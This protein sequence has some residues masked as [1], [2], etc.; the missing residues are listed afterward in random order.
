MK[1]FFFS[2]VMFQSLGSNGS[3]SPQVYITIYNLYHW[4]YLD[5]K[6]MDSFFLFLL[7]QEVTFESS[8]CPFVCTT[9]LVQFSIPPTN[10][11]T[12]MCP[13]SW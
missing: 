4:I 9:I 8:Y 12:W 13:L 7:Y 3:V 2:Y 10:A 1:E 11:S 6:F 5:Y